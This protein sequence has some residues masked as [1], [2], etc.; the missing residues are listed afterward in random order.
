M[1]KVQ[2]MVEIS[3]VQGKFHIFTVLKYLLEKVLI[4]NN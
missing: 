1:W 2:I 4:F 3:Q